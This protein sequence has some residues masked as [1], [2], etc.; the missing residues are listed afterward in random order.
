MST[1]L[2]PSE[3][4][5]LCRLVNDYMEAARQPIQAEKIRLWKA[6]NRGRMV[7]PM[8]TID[9][10]P[11]HELACDELTTHI[12]D[13]YWAEVETSLRQTLYK[14]RH[15]PVDMVIDPFIPIPK[16]LTLTGYG[17]APDEEVI[18]DANASAISHQ[19]HNQ[20]QTLEDVNKIQDYH[21]RHDE[22][23]TA[24]RLEEAQL[25]FGDL[26]PAVPMGCTLHLGVWDTL[27]MLMG[28]E[29]V[30]FALV[31]QPELLHAAMERITQSM[32][33][34]IGDADA[35]GA[36]NDNANICHCSHIYTDELLP[37]SGEGRGPLAQNCW[38][39][40]MAQ[41]FTSTSPAVFEEFELPYISR[42]AEKFGMLYYGCCERLDDRL[43][44]VKR[45]PHVRK[46]SCSPWSDRKRFAE[47]IGPDLVMSNK[48]N[49]AFLADSSLEEAV[50]E[51]DLRRTCELAVQNRVNAEFLLK[52][53]STV[54][55]DPTRLQKW[56]AVAMRVVEDYS[57]AY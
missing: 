3:K 19:Y 13:P 16:A 39:F 27:S 15:F 34:A 45:I 5:I 29:N 26:A 33:C 40:G 43:E 32:L 21:I 52:D 36:H 9:Q 44:L 35:C 37:G 48:P 28:V 17:I 22:A 47:N 51:E 49:P 6:L 38:A 1:P 11:W 57:V 18:G 8:V 50:I 4:D 31:D 23:Q 30:Y 54:R 56:A 10:L 25:L 12:R 41:L 42:M 14:W 46:V 2:N 55:G 24:Q 7:R 20:I 53:I